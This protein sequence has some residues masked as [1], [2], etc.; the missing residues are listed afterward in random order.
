MSELNDPVLD[1]PGSL[2]IE[3]TGDAA[4]AVLTLRGDLDLATAPNLTAAVAAVAGEN[5]PVLVL[6]LT[7]VG[8]LASAGLTALLAACREAPE[9]T[10]MRIVASGRATLRPIQLTGLESSLPLYRTLEEALPAE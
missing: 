6:D 9:G 7:E 2:S 5:P 10:E 4:A 8:F 1:P 3:R